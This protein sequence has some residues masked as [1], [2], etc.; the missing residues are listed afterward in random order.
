MKYIIQI[1]LMLCCC[2]HWWFLI[3]CVICLKG[4]AARK[5]SLWLKKIRSCRE[6]AKLCYQES[7]WC[8][9]L[10]IFEVE[11]HDDFSYFCSAVI[12]QYVWE[13]FHFMLWFCK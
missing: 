7:W 6:K 9:S 5:L 2:K 13:R 4:I 10:L 3:T 1:Q 11:M 12:V 8:F